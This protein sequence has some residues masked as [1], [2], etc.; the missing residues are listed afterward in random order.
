MQDAYFP[1]TLLC[2]SISWRNT[3]WFYSNIEITDMY[4][5]VFY[6][7]IIKYVAL[8]YKGYFVNTF[9]ELRHYILESSLYYRLHSG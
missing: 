9:T 6:K 2:I 7:F 5:S 3:H 8:E 4:M 1:Y